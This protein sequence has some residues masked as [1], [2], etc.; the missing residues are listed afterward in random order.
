MREGSPYP[1]GAAWDGRGTNFAVFSANATKVEVC[2]F[3]PSGHR[4]LQRVALPEYTDQIWH[5]Y[6]PGIRP[7][8]PYGLRVHGPYEPSAGHRF[9]AN[10]LLL[11]PYACA[12][13]GALTWD[14][15]IFGYRMESADDLTFDER[16]SA[17][18]VPKCR[19]VDEHL[20]G[21]ASAGGG[22]LRGKPPSCMKRTCAVTPNGIPACAKNCAGP[23]PG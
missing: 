6:L 18:F 19:V 16:D 22:S 8:T 10:K 20:I 13:L 1:R 12:Y 21:T 14:P 4:E 17:P 9:N 23:M 2:I 7:G 15:A 5:G 3:D 11:D